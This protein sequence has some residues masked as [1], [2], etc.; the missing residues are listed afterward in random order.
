VIALAVA[1]GLAVALGPVVAGQV[2]TTPDDPRRHVLPPLLDA[3]DENPLI[4]LSGWAVNPDQHLF[5]ATVDSDSRIRLAVLTEFDG[6]TWR[7]G[8][9][10]RSAGRALPPG[11]DEAAG[12]EVAVDTVR[13]QITIA[14]LAGHLLPTVAGPRRVDGVR[15]AYDAESGTLVRPEGLTPGVSYRAESRRPRPDVNVLPG[16]DVPAGPAT[17]RLLRLGPGAPAEMERLA[18][19][20]TEGS[21]APYQRAAAIETF[22]A[23]HYRLAGD[24]PSGHA[25][26]NLEFF[27]FA[28]QNAGGQRG[29]SE[30]FAAAFAVLARIVG[31]PSRVVVGFQ[32]RAGTA[33]VTAADALAW[34]EVLFTGVGWVPFHPLPEPDT[35]ARPVEEDFRPE[36]EES[37]PPPSAVPTIALSVEPPSRAPD[38]APPPPP[39]G[40]SIL[41]VLATVAGGL[42]LLGLLGFGTAVPLLRRGLR[43]RRLDRG[44]PDE[45]VAGAWLEVA[46]ALRLARRAAPPHL[47]ATEVAAHA[48][49][50]AGLPRWA[51]RKGRVRLPAPPLDELAGIVNDSV[52]GPEPASEEAAGRARAQAVAYIDELRS[53]RPWWHRLLWTLHPGPLRWRR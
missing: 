27:L 24:A 34:P 33:R 53:R 45:R 10:Y 30:Q 6:V 12:P 4:R 47:A 23:E 31:L 22:L 3:L 19:Q 20:I 13:Q 11:G 26:P 9:V 36:P 25:Y 32:V 39:V 21:A 8:G 50:A 35:Q 48:G 38:A 49:T 16:A 2:A 46:D 18:R 28:A 52:F 44:A 5:D 42:V 17:A 40:G 15:V 43:R 29:T 14:D 41:P 37:E 7:V 51:H 1:T